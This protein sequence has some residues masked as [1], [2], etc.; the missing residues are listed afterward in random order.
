M[1]AIYNSQVGGCPSQQD[2][3]SAAIAIQSPGYDLSRKE[4][5]IIRSGDNEMKN[6]KSTWLESVTVRSD[7]E[8]ASRFWLTVEHKSWW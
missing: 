7:M 2:Y 5:K 3:S 6:K 4:K 8:T 1:R